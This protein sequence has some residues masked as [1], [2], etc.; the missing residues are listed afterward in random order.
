MSTKLLNRVVAEVS[1][2]ATLR[3][4]IIVPFILQ[5]LGAVGLV[6]YLSFR[7]GQQAV[8]DVASQLRREISDRTSDALG[9]T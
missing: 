5:I 3:T 4:V 9:L 7:N 6:A 1:G 8:N 2:K